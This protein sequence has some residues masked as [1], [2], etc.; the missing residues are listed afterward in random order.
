MEQGV[1]GSNLGLSTLISE[2]G[3]LLLPSCDMTDVLLKQRKRWKQLNP[4][5]LNHA[6]VGKVT[7]R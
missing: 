4:T 2:I 1:Q 5:Q 3:Y 6:M 7:M